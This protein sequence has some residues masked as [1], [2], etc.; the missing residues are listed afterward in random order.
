V[1]S[2]RPLLRWWRNFHEMTKHTKQR[3][4][5]YE[6]ERVERYI[7]VA[8]RV[9]MIMKGDEAMW[10]GGDPCFDSAVD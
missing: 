4:Q 1:P 9:A 2:I 6:G 10:C 7:S 5:R 8:I 3:L